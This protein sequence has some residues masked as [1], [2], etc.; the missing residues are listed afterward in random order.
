MS[1]GGGGTGNPWPP[2]Q[3]GPRQGAVGFVGSVPDPK[4]SGAMA[5]LAISRSKYAEPSECQERSA[6]LY[7]HPASTRAPDP[8]RPSTKNARGP[9]H[10]EFAARRKTIVGFVLDAYD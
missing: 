10:R 8:Q 3:A 5:P 9:I 7:T 1:P 6:P 2:E 4:S